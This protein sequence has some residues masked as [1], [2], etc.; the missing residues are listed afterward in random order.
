MRRVF[1]MAVGAAA[2]ATGTVWAQRNVRSRLEERTPAQL[3]GQVAGAVAGQG[4]RAAGRGM[5]V[6]GRNVAAA[7][8]EGRQA[9]GEREVELRRSLEVSASTRPVGGRG[10]SGARRAPAAGAPA[11]RR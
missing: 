6:M 4:V 8:N 3:A 7:V 5:A 1:W 11:A 2:G 9:A 10:R